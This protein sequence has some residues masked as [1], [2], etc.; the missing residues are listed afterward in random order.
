MVRALIDRP[1]IL[2]S[3]LAPVKFIDVLLRTASYFGSLDEAV[4]SRQPFELY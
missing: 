3:I 4:I 2:T 1:T